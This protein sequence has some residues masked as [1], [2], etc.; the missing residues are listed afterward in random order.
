MSKSLTRREVL[1]GSAVGLGALALPEWAFPALVQGEELVKFTDY[2]EG[3]TTDRGPE[4]RRYDIRRIDGPITP[5]E[6]FFTTQHHGHP[7]IDGASFRLKVSGLVDRPKE[8]SLDELRGL[9]AVAG[10][11]PRPRR[12][13]VGRGI[14]VLRQPR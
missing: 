1:H 13:R 7:Q 8:L 10:R 5:T 14:R 11:A 12:D 4:R 3:W 9:G 6:E 2:P